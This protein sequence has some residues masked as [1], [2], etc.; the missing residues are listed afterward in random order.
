[1]TYDLTT[2]E[3]IK[4]ASEWFDKYGW[5]VNIYAWVL[6]KLIGAINPINKQTEMAKEII[7][8]GKENGASDLEIIVDN[9]AGLD[10]GAEYGGIPIQAKVGTDGKMTLK[11]NYK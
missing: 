9:K 1:M 11:V 5:S 4:N 6:K 7:K 10:L 2:K 8:A 3:G